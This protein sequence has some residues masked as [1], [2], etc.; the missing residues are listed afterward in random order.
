MTACHV[1]AA[2]GHRGWLWSLINEHHANVNVASIDLKTPLSIAMERGDI[3][4]VSMLVAA[5]AD[6][7]AICRSD[8]TTL[9]HVAINSGFVDIAVALIAAGA[10]VNADDSDGLTPWHVAV[11]LGDAVLLERAIAAGADVNSIVFDGNTA[12]HIATAARHDD[13]IFLDACWLLAQMRML[14]TRTESPHATWRWEVTIH[15]AH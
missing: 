11:A 2:S 1:A 12:L 7:N 15:C 6:V 4:M 9:L 14:K 5:N 13:T 8:G 10:N 3:K